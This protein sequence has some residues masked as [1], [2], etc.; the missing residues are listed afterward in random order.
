MRI[1][2]SLPSMGLEDNSNGPEISSTHAIMFC[3]EINHGYTLATCDVKWFNLYKTVN[4]K[5]Y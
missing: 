5:N 2:N 4:T 3:F 1:L